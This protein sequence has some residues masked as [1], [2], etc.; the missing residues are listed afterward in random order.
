VILSLNLNADLSLKDFREAARLAESAGYFRIWIGE[1]ISYGHSFS[2]LAMAAEET[3]RIQIGAGILSPQLNRCHHIVRAF[4]TLQEVYGERFAVALAPG[5]INEVQSA[6][7]NSAKPIETVLQCVKELKKRRDE[8]KWKLPVYVGAS[9][10]RL[11][12]EGSMLADGVLLN[13][14]HPEF[15][16]WAIHQM[17]RKTF[18]AAYGPALL[19]PDPVNEPLLREA[20]TTVIT[21]ANEVFLR[22]FSLTSQAERAREILASKHSKTDLRLSLERFV[23]AGKLTEM[24]AMLEK[25]FDKG[26]DEIILATPMCR[27]LASVKTLAGAL[28]V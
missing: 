7:A 6:G 14:I 25:L 9:G 12:S 13:Y 22:E 23:L 21:G 24:K 20:A 26:V 19:L 4:Q 1:S 11:I 8:K 16:D 5:D 27:N 10:P 3:R 15:V 28:I 18:A 2:F 17:K